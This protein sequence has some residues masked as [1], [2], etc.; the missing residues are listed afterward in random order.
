MGKLSQKEDV[1]ELI[2]IAAM[3]AD[4]LARI[5]ERENLLV[6]VVDRPTNPGNL[7]TLI[8]SCD[9]LRVDGVIIRTCH[10][11][12]LYDPE[13][14]RATVGSFFSLPIIRLPSSQEL[15]PGWKG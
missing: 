1:S 9:A 13:T 4:D 14:I 5:P 2:A 12:D 7:G 15:I 8:R 11:V 10:S 6:V 3:P